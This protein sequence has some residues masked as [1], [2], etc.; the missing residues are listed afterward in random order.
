M[1]LGL[2]CLSRHPCCLQGC[3]Y[4][5]DVGPWDSDPPTDVAMSLDGQ[6][7]FVRQTFSINVQSN[8]LDKVLRLLTI[9][10]R[11]IED[12]V[13]LLILRLHC[14][15]LPLKISLYYCT[16]THHFLI[17]SF[18]RGTSS[19]VNCNDNFGTSGKVRLIRG[20]LAPDSSAEGRTSTHSFF[21]LT[22]RC[23]N[24]SH[25]LSASDQRRKVETRTLPGWQR[26]QKLEAVAR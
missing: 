14:S 22:C 7:P 25:L 8:F 19:P 23:H 15:L 20:W 16:R 6:T 4:P 13:L 10:L 26:P 21:A 3:S 17:G 1:N 18:N 9:K 12:M 5:T 11:D 2:H 24:S